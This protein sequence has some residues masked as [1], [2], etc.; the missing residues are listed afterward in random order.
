M[1]RRKRSAK[2]RASGLPPHGEPPPPLAKFLRDAP[3]SADPDDRDVASLEPLTRHPPNATQPRRPARRANGERAGRRARS[4]QERERTLQVRERTLQVR[5]R[6]LMKPTRPFA[7]R[8]LRSTVACLLLLASLLLLHAAAGTL[9]LRASP[10]ASAG[11]GWHVSLA[12]KFMSGSALR[13]FR[14]GLPARL[15]NLAAGPVRVGVQV[16]HLNAAEQPD[17]LA[18]LRFSTGADA[19]GRTEVEVN[20]AVAEALAARLT[21]RGVHVDLLPATIPPGYAADLLLSLHADA[22]DDPNRN[23]YKSA[24][25]HPARNPAEA[26]LKVAVDRAVLLMTGLK[27]DDVNVSGNMLHYYAFNHER[28]EHAVSRR[29]PALIVE[30]GYLTNAHD[31]R[32]LDDPE[33][34]AAALEAGALS[35]LRDIN[36]WQG[37]W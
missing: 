5:E 6:T 11:A 15:A 3:A 33:R 17:E 29:T 25:F 26:I 32:L 34:L 2:S 31:A 36:R 1:R 4:L 30:L 21:E 19:G 12:D 24:H 16:G 8:L 7:A 35:Y 20:L 23:G 18:S 28:F 27:D 13:V 9:A 10:Q 14:P 37:A 22:S